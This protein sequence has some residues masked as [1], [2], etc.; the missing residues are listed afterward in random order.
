[1]IRWI[2]ALILEICT[3]CK[4]LYADNYSTQL[5]TLGLEHKENNYI[6]HCMT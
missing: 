1:M 3:I 5:M 2:N 6:I 4:D